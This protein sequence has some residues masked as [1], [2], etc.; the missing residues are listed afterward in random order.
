MT[1]SSGVKKPVVFLFATY[2]EP[3]ACVGLVITWG[4]QPKIDLL[5]LSHP[6]MGPEAGQ[7]SSE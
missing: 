1:F 6:H 7:L 3:C 4:C 2:I 5:P